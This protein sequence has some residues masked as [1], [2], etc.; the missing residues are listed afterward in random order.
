[1][2]RRTWRRPTGPRFAIGVDCGQTTAMAI[3]DRY[4]ARWT[5]LLTLDWWEAVDFLR[6][7]AAEPGEY[8]LWVEDP[9]E[10]GNIY[11]RHVHAFVAAVRGGRGGGW[12][13]KEAYRLLK[14]AQDVGRNKQDARRLI[15][16]AT[17][18]GL[19]VHALAPIHQK[20][21]DA[22]TLAQLGVHE[23]RTNQHIR[24]AMRLAW[25]R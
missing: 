12:V 23:G 10:V 19:E 18:L 13:L 2:K 17:A 1:M 11:S 5:D 20:K 8:Q 14:I 16:R 6:E 4:E 24:D 25:R 15:E 9:G 7:L 21:W 22:K 3:W